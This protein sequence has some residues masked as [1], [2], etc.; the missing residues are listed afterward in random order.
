MNPRFRETRGVDA[1]GARDPTTRAEASRVI[2][3][4]LE[5]PRKKGS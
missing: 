2:D 5:C 1:V 4:L 3:L